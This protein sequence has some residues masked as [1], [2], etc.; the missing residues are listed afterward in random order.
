M[1]AR[2]NDGKV[3]V[4]ISE[5][6][7]SDSLFDIIHFQWIEELFGWNDYNSRVMSSLLKR[8]DQWK[9]RGASIVSTIHNL[10]PHAL[11]AEHGCEIYMKVFQKTDL[12]IH[13]GRISI[14]MFNEIYGSEMFKRG[15]HFVIPHGLYY[16]FE[17]NVDRN[18]ARSYF[19]INDNNFVMLAFG[20]IRNS[21]EERLIMDA[22]KAIETKRKNVI[23]SNYNF[24]HHR[25]MKII[26][27]TRLAINKNIFAVSGFVKKEMVPYFFAASDIVF[28]PRIEVLN[29]GNLL[30]GFFYEKVVVGPDTG[31]VGEI[32]RETGNP[33]FAPGNKKSLSVA[34]NNAKKLA[35]Y[36]N[37]GY[38]NFSYANEKYNW[39]KI[40][41]M[42]LKAYESVIKN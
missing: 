15:R 20:N 23:I 13:L 4:G 9:N 34:V 12:F 41:E 16:T 38:E 24:S 28:I 21:E 30:L 39:D 11:P 10:H 18:S 32:L 2:L 40:S 17:K 3:T 27:K 36:S 33:V 25:L 8:I 6:W 31:V 22:Y 14:K 35:E 29:S 42:H 19:G 7:N 37:K 5:F 1:S 26:Q